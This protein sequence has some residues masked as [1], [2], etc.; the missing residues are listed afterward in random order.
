MR[1]FLLA[2]ILG[3]L[4]VALVLFLN[5]QFP[6]VLSRE[7]NQAEL[8][9]KVVV[10]TALVG[11]LAVSLQHE[12]LGSVLRS[13]LVWVVLGLVLVTGYSFKDELEPLWQRVAGNLVPAQ[14][15]SLGPGVTALRAANDG[16]F[17]VVAEVTVGGIPGQR[18]RFMVDTGASDVALTREDAERLGID[19]ERLRFNIPYSTANGT[20]FGA[21][22]RLDRVRIGDVVVDNVAGSVVSGRLDQSL[23]GMSF[24]R[25]LSGFEFR[26]NEM[27]LRQ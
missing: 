2:A 24:L 11:S 21:H 9:Q 17:H 4:T 16:H 8:I 12:R 7:E 10:L 5:A 6:G 27:V 22:V 26:G 19:V 1:P 15:V 18:V 25:R 3:A 13:M 23:L 20:S 14:P